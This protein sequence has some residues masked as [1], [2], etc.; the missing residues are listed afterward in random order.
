MHSAYQTST[1]SVDVWQPA[2]GL[3]ELSIYD[4]AF[5][6]GERRSRETR[7]RVEGDSPV[8]ATARMLAAIQDW[9]EDVGDSSAASAIL[10]ERTPVTAL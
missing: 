10:I 1:S 9:Y 3:A 8:P 5:R 2:V 4:K 7:G 6:T